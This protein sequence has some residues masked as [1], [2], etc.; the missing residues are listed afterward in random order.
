MVA[1]RMTP[2][3]FKAEYR[4]K[5]WT[6]RMLADRW[7]KSV[8]WISKIGNDPDR[9]AHWDDAVR[10]LPDERLNYSSIY[11]LPWVDRWFNIAS[12]D[13][14][15]RTSDMTDF[16]AVLDDF[17]R[18]SA[19][20]HDIVERVS[21]EL[22]RFFNLG[23]KFSWLAVKNQIEIE[24]AKKGDAKGSVALAWLKAASDHRLHA[25]LSVHGDL[26][27]NETE[28]R[29]SELLIIA[30]ALVAE[31]PG[32]LHPMATLIERALASGLHGQRLQASIALA[33]SQGEIIVTPDCGPKGLGVFQLSKDL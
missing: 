10:G 1:Q 14:P 26:V 6:G 30:R 11:S 27:I 32:K 25:A 3:E 9:E 2:S 7:Q 5:G 28:N 13:D 33:I 8:A 17:N 18:A 20:E 29:A 19:A 12:E 21:V 4:R 31:R 22:W 15:Q 23:E 16:I 24:A